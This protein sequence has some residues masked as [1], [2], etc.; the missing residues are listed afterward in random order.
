MGDWAYRFWYLRAWLRH[1]R[2]KHTLVAVEHWHKTEGDYEVKQ[3]GWKCWLCEY[4]EI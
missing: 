3:R 1:T 4:R 2:G